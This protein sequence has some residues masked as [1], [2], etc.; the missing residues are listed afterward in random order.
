MARDRT[1][2]REIDWR[3][4]CP[5]LILFRTV[6]SAVDPRKLLSAAAGL[7]LVTGGWA[8]LG[9]LFAASDDPSVAA[10]AERYK[11]LTWLNQE[12]PAVEGP[13][14][15]TK[16]AEP[17]PFL[18]WRRLADAALLIPLDMARPFLEVFDRDAGYQ[19]IALSLLCALWEVLVW[20]FFAGVITRMSAL[21]LSQDLNA[22]W[23][24]AMRH[25]RRKYVSYAA[26]PL[27]PI[28]FLI[29]CA[30]LM[31][32]FGLLSRPNAGFVATA[33]LWPL[34][35]IF[36]ILLAAVL[37]SLLFGWPIFWTTISAENTD[38]FDGFARAFAY[39]YQRS[40]SYLFYLVLAAVLGVIGWVALAYFVEFTLFIC[41]W[42]VSWGTGQ[43]RGVELLSLSRLDQFAAPLS[44]GGEIISFWSTAA[45]IIVISY[46]Y[47]FFWTAFTAIYLLLR[48]DTDA[49]PLDVVY[50]DEPLGRP[51]PPL[52]HDEAGV[53]AAP[54]DAQSA[55]EATAPP[56]E[57]E[58]SPSA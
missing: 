53:P 24:K 44:T 3:E 25:V 1:V 27:L 33:A 13:A 14:D 18:D 32:L 46:G 41:A 4:V 6:W 2:V 54:R 10:Q 43:E 17:R 55:G 5:W 42:G 56:S 57:A 29:G 12:A 48:R 49:T 36:C 19:N 31:S 52:D 28:F 16:A 8:V 38:A 58:G 11:A 39:V 20:A 34:G 26:A 30:L 22:S 15:M 23:F 21:Q 47:S 50:L 9:D 7:L 37:V 35:L 45:R 51:L 40:F